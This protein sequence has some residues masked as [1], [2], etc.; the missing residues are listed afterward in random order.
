MCN[1]IYKNV[2]KIRI[3]NTT[4]MCRVVHFTHIQTYFVIHFYINISFNE[5][6]CKFLDVSKM[7]DIKHKINSYIY[8]LMLRQYLS[9]FKYY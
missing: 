6:L 7:I 8:N 3:I 5:Y 1:I 2:C 9:D 4:I